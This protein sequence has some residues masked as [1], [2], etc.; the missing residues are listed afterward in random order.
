MAEAPPRVYFSLITPVFNPPRHAFEDCVTSVLNQTYTSWQ[1]CLVDDCSTEPWIKHRLAELQ[2]LDERIVVHFRT[3]NGGIA[4]ASNDALGL[5]LGEFV[6]FLDHDDVLHH[7]ALEQ[8]HGV[9]SLR[10][11]I[12]FLYTDEDKIDQHNMFYEHFAKPK[13]SP[14][15]LLGQNYCSHLSVARTQLVNDVGRFRTGFEGAQDYDLFLRLTERAREIAHLPKTLYHWRAG[16]GST[17]LAQNEKPYAHLAAVEAV[18][19]ALVRRKIKATVSA[20]DPWPYQRII[21]E[22]PQEPLISIIIPTCGTYKTVFGVE[23]CLVINAVESILSKSSYRNYELL[24]IIDNDTSERVW[25]GLRSIRDSRVHLVRYDKPFNFASKCN[26]GSVLS[27]GEHLLML[28]DDTEV[29]DE[30]WLHTL[31]GYLEEPD[32]AMVGPMLLLEDGRIQSAGHSNNPSPH[33]FRSGASAGDPGEFGVLTIA[34]E[35]SGITGACALIRKTVYDE[36]GGMSPVFPKAFNDVDLGFKI[37]EAGYRIIWTPHTRVYHFETA[38]RDPEVDSEEVV[39]LL[40][41]WKSKFDADLYCR[42]T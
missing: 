1:W 12:D 19:S 10:D 34:R 5:S 31:V 9:L 29:I 3:S 40:D 39:L 2:A 11:E 30:H 42:L 32:V 41:R 25:D 33:N 15:R 13:W 6:A 26:L 27:R 20:A 22:V 18:K 14:E 8:V 38:S 24:V 37:L 4:E 21:R 7:E 16:S 36:V 23:T 28:N 35:T 17:A